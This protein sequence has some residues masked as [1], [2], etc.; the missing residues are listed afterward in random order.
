MTIEFKN[1]YHLGD[2]LYHIHYSNYILQENPELT[3]INYMEPQYITECN[4][5][6]WPENI[7]RMLNKEITQEVKDN[8]NIESTWIE[9]FNYMHTNWLSASR[10][11][12]FNDYMNMFYEK[13]LKPYKIKYTF[14]NN[15]SGKFNHPLLL[16]KSKEL[17]SYDWLIINSLPMS[18]QWNYVPF[19]FDGF[20]YDLNSLGKTIITTKQS[21]HNYIP[22]TLE[23]APSLFDV[24]AQSI[25]CKNLLGVHTAPFLVSVN[26]HSNYE[27]F[28]VLQR[29]KLNYTGGTNFTNNEQLNTYLKDLVRK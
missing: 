3:I 2:N 10:T 29:N 7:N 9:N 1:E 19:I 28:I 6:I 23:L 20:I 16:E 25:N 11:K 24:A 15:I 27:Q 18:G 13:L 12:H 5:W 17:D 4:K 8:K 21:F 26:D 22:C 14:L